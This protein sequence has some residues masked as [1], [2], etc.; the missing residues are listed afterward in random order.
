MLIDT[1]VATLCL[2]LS[3]ADMNWMCPRRGLDPLHEPKMYNI[4]LNSLVLSTWI[5][6]DIHF[7]SVTEGH[8]P[9]ILMVHKWLWKLSYQS[10]HHSSLPEVCYQLL[11]SPKNLISAALSSSNF[12]LS[13][14]FYFSSVFQ[15][16]P[17]QFIKLSII[18]S[19]TKQGFLVFQPEINKH[20]Y[21]PRMNYKSSHSSQYWC[22]SRS[23]F[24]S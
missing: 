10:L 19:L 5:V 7:F 18:I 15:I 12:S 17:S 9:L 24:Y 16:Y 4:S 22:F 2:V 23:Q 1:H 14:G 3:S 20:W 6:A 13:S 11:A 8:F 21:Q